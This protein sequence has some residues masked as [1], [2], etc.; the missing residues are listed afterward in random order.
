MDQPDIC[1]LEI[2]AIMRDCWERNPADRPLFSQI[3]DRIGSILKKH[4][5][6]VRELKFY[7]FYSCLSNKQKAT[8]V[9]PQ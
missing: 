2:Y 6:S 8:K 7:D 4:A 9:P 1:P 5:G 3:N